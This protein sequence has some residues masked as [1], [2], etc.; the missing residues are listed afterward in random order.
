MYSYSSAVV[1]SV[2]SADSQDYYVLLSPSI[3]RP[4]VLNSTALA[5]LDHF[6]SP[7]A[8]RDIPEEWIIHWGQMNIEKTL[9]QMISL[10]FLVP[11]KHIEPVV[12]VHYSRLS[13]W[14]HLTNRC[15]LACT[16]CYNSHKAKDM[17]LDIGKAAIAKL[18][19]SAKIQN[20]QEVKIKYA[21]GEPLLCFSTI[22]KLHAHAKQLAEQKALKIDGVVLSNGILLTSE[23][24]K[25]LRR[26]GL[27][28]M[29]SLDHMPSS[30]PYDKGN[31]RTY[32]DG[33]DSSK[34]AIQAIE[35]ALDSDIVPEVSIT[36]SSQ[37]VHQ[38]PDLL[39]WILAHNLPF[40]LNFCRSHQKSIIKSGYP[41]VDET[42]FV[43]GML[44]AYKVIESNLPHRSLL[45]SLADMANFSVPHLHRCGVGYNY[46]V[47]DTDGQVSKCQM[48]MEQLVTD[49]NA[50]DPLGLIRADAQG[51]QNIAVNEKEGCQD[52]QWK[53]WCAGGC[54]LE[55]FR[56]TGRYDARSPHCNIYKALYPEV[57]KLE[58]LRL[59]KYANT[60]RH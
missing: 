4:S 59:L 10:G 30:I 29:I 14:L 9:T 26:S 50:V 48:Q 16:Y 12:M 18:F 6:K 22:K 27:R 54:P 21:G 31:Q 34:E 32:P 53:Y 57:L 11:E 60:P 17:S 28:L 41:G 36:V 39:T 56:M 47:F 8:L 51:I 38:L 20:F 2:I 52:C 33:K 40:S 49:V 58:G 46:L 1:E 43:E 5:C 23:M 24:A 42:Y 45:T 3:E 44:A 15:P 37:S 35:I 55:T 19:H 13:A 7:K 25:E